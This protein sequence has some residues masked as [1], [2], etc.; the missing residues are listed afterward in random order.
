MR[1]VTTI[2]LALSTVFWAFGQ[3]PT[4]KSM[5][6]DNTY[7]FYDVV[8]SANAYFSTH[9]TGEGSGHKPFQRWVNENESKFYPSGDRLNAY[10]DGARI[11][12]QQLKHTRS[13]TL[14]KT[15][16]DGWEE[17]GPWEANNITS[18]Y[19]PGIGRVET[20]WVNPSNTD[21]I[22]LGSR[23]GGFWKTTDGGQ[24]WFCST[25]TLY[26]TGV[27]SIA[28]NP[29][30][31]KDVI[32]ATRQG[33]NANAYSLYRS[34]DGGVTWAITKF[35]P[36]NTGIGGLGRNNRFYKVVF[37]PT[38]QGMIFIG[39]S[40]GLYVSKDNL[41]SWT[42]SFTGNAID[43]DF[44]PTEP[45][46][47][48][49]FNNSGT[50]R[51]YLKISRDTGANFSNSAQL[52]NNNNAKCFI[53]VSPAE[54]KHV[55]MASNN[56]VWRSTNEGAFF[57]FLTNP[58][59]SCQGFAVS[60]KDVTNM[61]YGYVDTEA[62]TDGGKSFQ[63]VTW[64]SNR[65]EAYVHA[66]IRA[67]ECLDGV[68]Y[69]GTDG[70][71][72]KSD[73]N[74]KTWTRLNDGTGIRE[75]YAVGLSQSDL[76]QHMAGSQDNG[77]SILNKDGWLE[78]NGGDGMEALIY[79]LNND[80]MIGSWQYGSRNTTTNGGLTRRAV[81][82][83]ESGS[84]NADWEAPLLMDPEDHMM[85]YHFGKQIFKSTD[86]GQNWELFSSPGLL[87]NGSVREIKDAAMSETTS[88]VM[89][90]SRNS[91]LRLTEDGG[92][93]WKNIEA[94]LPGY[95]ITDIAFDPKNDSTIVVTYNRHQN[96]SRKIYISHN[97]GNTWSNITNNLNNMPLRTVVIDH[98]DKKH[99]YVGG[100]I[101]VYYMEMGGSTWKLL[102]DDLPNV[103]VKDLEIQ[104]GSNIIK[105]ASWGRGLWQHSLPGKEDAPRIVKTSME[106]TPS[107]SQPKESISQII[108]C[109]I[110]SETGLDS[111]TLYYSINSSALDQQSS[112]T[113]TTGNSWQLNEGIP[114]P[115]TDDVVYFKII[116]TDK[117]GQIAETFRFVYIIRPFEYCEGEG[118][119]GTGADWINSVEMNGVAKISAKSQYSDF[120]DTKFEL[121][122]GDSYELTI[123]CN[124]S[125]PLDTTAA[126]IDFNNDRKFSENEMI[127]MSEL[128]GN[129]TAKGTVTVPS[130]AV[131]YEDLR[132]RV[133]VSYSNVIEPCGTESGEVEDY[134]IRLKHGK[135]NSLDNL[136]PGFYS[137][138]PN[139]NT[140]DFQLRLDNTY[141][142][143]SISIYTIDGREVMK[144]DYHNV[145]TAQINRQLKP[146]TYLV[147]VAAD[148]HYGNKKIIIQ[149]KN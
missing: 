98:T 46:V 119:T 4:Y 7:N 84:G 75:F 116:A 141:K 147:H 8:D 72:A 74:G 21:E 60:D 139:P 69:L 56:G 5:M 62:S 49:A 92:K 126:W 43:I 99:I 50:D 18:H 96:D 143:V 37:H 53:A 28:V 73:D 61:V 1:I 142:N 146:G 3:Q 86:F 38:R 52:N 88:L 68:F 17:L 104:Y 65:N 101:G 109:E 66:D 111:V 11:A 107:A 118:S 145:S 95:S 27:Q 23:S 97:R 57:T 117:N 64:W 19:S 113:N 138:N 79:P 63:Q 85:V 136:E 34:N 115:Q 123:G 67:A 10:Y 24:N 133:R 39:T 108:T 128:T 131:F 77:T 148:G 20:F 30:D 91:V 110:E 100:E 125:F 22:M 121:I 102:G 15:V 41:N 134:T 83:P 16:K 80:I 44:H 130:D 51:N 33:G 31:S 40:S 149:P 78:W 70:Y 135:T 9:G 35:N 103:T 2:F 42:R 13:T 114:S 55:Y 94:G 144:A 36:A 90:I 105:A 25:D 48:Y 12:H 106:N 93:T 6:Y 140:G 127:V 71:L 124:Y 120:T 14:G 137:V 45:K 112:M 26:V 59:E 29:F 76:T 32:I 89:A 132:M 81:G 47:V 58:D 122:E 87:Q 129:H 54:P 82:N